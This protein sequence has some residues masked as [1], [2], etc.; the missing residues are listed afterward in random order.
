M[1]LCLHPTFKSCYF[2]FD[3]LDEFFFEIFFSI[4]ELFLIY[5]FT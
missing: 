3:I 4:L 2:C 5:D 1:V